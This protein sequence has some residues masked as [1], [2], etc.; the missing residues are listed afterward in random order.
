MIQNPQV[1]AKA[2]SEIDTMVG[3]NRLPSFDDR[4]SLPYIDAVLRET[5][6]W[7]PVAPLGIAHAVSNDDIY[8]GY[9]LPKGATVIANAWAMSHDESIYFN[10][11]SFEPDRFLSEGRLT[12]DNASYVFGFGRR[13][14]VGRHAA[15]ASVWSAI[16]S[17]LAVFTIKK[18]ID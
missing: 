1:Q 16:V 11:F 3:H 6:R 14:C 4:P 13:I 9:H 2:Q 5:L 10:P 17:F 8:E 12:D 15:D 18:A 7:H